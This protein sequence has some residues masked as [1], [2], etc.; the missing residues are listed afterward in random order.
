MS[1]DE[2]EKPGK[3]LSRRK[4][5]TRLGV[6]VAAAAASACLPEAFVKEPSSVKHSEIKEGDT[7]FLVE[8][9]PLRVQYDDGVAHACQRLNAENVVEEL[10]FNPGATTVRRLGELTEEVFCRGLRVNEELAEKGKAKLWANPQ[11]SKEI[12]DLETGKELSGVQVIMLMGDD[13]I[14]GFTPSREQNAHYEPDLG[15]C[16]AQGRDWNA[17][18]VSGFVEGWFVGEVVGD[19]E[20]PVFKA[21]GY[22]LPGVLESVEARAGQ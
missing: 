7:L 11:G 13:Y 19:K 10:S 14:P 18:S 3:T 8:G 2:Q 20:K 9:K 5:L 15:K 6:A 16:R 17:C 12:A 21:K 1:E 4:F 22:V